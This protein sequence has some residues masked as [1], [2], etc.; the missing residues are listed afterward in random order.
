MQ[1]KLFIFTLVTL[2]LV[3]C[4][5]SSAGPALDP[6]TDGFTVSDATQEELDE[7]ANSGEGAEG[8][9]T[10]DEETG[11]L[12]ITL[13]T[14]SFNCGP[15]A[16]T[17]TATVIS[18]SETELVVQF[19]GDSGNV[20]WTRVENTG[21]GI[22]GIWQTTDPNLY[23]ILNGDGS[24]QLFGEQQICDEDRP[25]NEEQCL[26]VN[27]ST[28]SITIDGDLGDWESVDQAATLTDAIGDQVGDDPGADAIAM[29]V[30]YANG[31]IFIL[32]EFA[33]PPSTA[34]QNSSAPNGGSYRLVVQGYNG[35][36]AGGTIYY[37]PQTESWELS[38]ISPNTSAAVGATG[39]EW[40]VDI[41]ANL[42]EGFEGVDLIMVQPVDC[43]V[44]SCE[45]LDSLDCAYFAL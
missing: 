27:A 42:G 7:A 10:H 14:S 32:S 18:L 43:S 34:F 29:K 24:A 22:V 8:S 39:I 31:T 35:L 5:G 15:V 38:S 19:G 28:A 33:A 13:S 30:A 36:S 3:A 12:T 21:S 9:Y 45:F 37:A 40:S 41:S 4:G 44:G 23:M 17:V 11:V 26:L 25:R 16:G 20:T 2:S 6:N 1:I